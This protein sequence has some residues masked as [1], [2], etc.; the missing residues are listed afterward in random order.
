M[1]SHE[2]PEYN[3]MIYE[4]YQQEGKEKHKD[5]GKSLEDSAYESED[6]GIYN[7]EVDEGCY[8]EEYS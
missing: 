8:S 3:K 7:Q 5:Y 2:D 4:E 1:N 6:G